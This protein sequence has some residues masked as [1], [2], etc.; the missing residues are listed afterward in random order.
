MLLAVLL[1]W[2]CCRSASSGFSGFAAGPCFGCQLARHS[3]AELAGF[4]AGLGG[5]RPAVSQP[6][7]WSWLLTLP[8]RRPA[9]VNSFP[10]QAPPPPRTRRSQEPAAVLAQL[11]AWGSWTRHL[12]VGHGR[13]EPWL[14]CT[15]TQGTGMSQCEVSGAGGSV[16]HRS[17]AEQE[18]RACSCS[19]AYVERGME[20]SPGLV[21]SGERGE[22][23]VARGPASSEKSDSGG[24]KPPRVCPCHGCGSEG[25]LLAGG[26]CASLRP[27][28]VLRGAA[29]LRLRLTGTSRGH[30]V[31]PPAKTGPPHAVGV[32]A[33]LASPLSQLLTCGDNW[34]CRAE[35]LRGAVADRIH[36]CRAGAV[37]AA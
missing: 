2:I 28:L 12:A 11:A 30:L 20:P 16:L 19:G 9:S 1:G 18:C 10:G 27:G 29:R 26:C 13:G 23:D 32:C 14:P 8:Q 34:R 35:Q 21:P 31:E 33:V 24:R 7:L 37:A 15:S 25:L 22:E 36:S 5:A 4:P 17:S 3:L 6:G